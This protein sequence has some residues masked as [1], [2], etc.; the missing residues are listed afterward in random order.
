MLLV[1]PELFLEFFS[2]L[3]KLLLTHPFGTA[4]I[5]PVE[6]LLEI[7]IAALLCV[8]SCRIDVRITFNR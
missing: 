6:V 7:L 1:E 8:P 5:I 2:V 3:T 4:L